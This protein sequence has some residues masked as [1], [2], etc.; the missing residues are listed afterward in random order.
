MTTRYFDGTKNI[1]IDKFPAEAWTV[2]TGDRDAD[3]MQRYASAVAFLFRAIEVRANALIA[4]PWKIGP[5]DGEPIWTSEDE[6]APAQ[7]EWA[8]N[9]PQLLWQSS[10]SWAFYNEA[11]WLRERNRVRTLDLRWLDPDSM[12]PKWDKDA[13]LVGF[14]RRIDAATIKPLKLDDVVYL[15]RQGMR[16]T[17]PAI[18]PAQAAMQAA[19][20]LYNADKFAADFFARGAIKATLL[21][22][23]GNPSDTELKRLESWWKRFFSGVRDAWSTA[24]VRA[25]VKAVPVGEGLESLSNATLTAEKREDIATAMG[26]PHSLVMS[27]AANF[28]TS[29]MDKRNFYDTTIIPDCLLMQR[30]LNRQLFTPI[31]LRFTFDPQEMAVYQE[32]ETKRS[33]AFQAYANAGLPL[34][35][36]AEMLGLYLPDGIEYA[37]LDVEPEPQPVQLQTQPMPEQA[38]GET[39]QQ[40]QNEMQRIEEVKRLRRWIKKR[41][42]RDVSDFASDILN[43]AEKVEISAQVKGEA[44]PSETGSPFRAAD[45]WESYP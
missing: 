5:P 35:I 21:S 3:D 37:D 20:V 7:L 12:T 41:P 16:E 17:E 10:V 30:Q 2:L 8:S 22:I 25:D 33:Q 32:D 44:Q 1:A 24:A 23:D 4:V 6:D 42:G 43:D 18:A 45:E 26:V 19:G 27:N 36:V 11:F 13:G 28:A 40:H 31:G 38:Q 14:E 29:E 34:S 9:L 15:W 39:M